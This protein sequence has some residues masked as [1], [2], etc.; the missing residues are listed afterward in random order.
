MR[1]MDRRRTIR[2]LAKAELSR[3]NQKIEGLRQQHEPRENI[4]PGNLH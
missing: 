3:I 4:V 1:E 2:E